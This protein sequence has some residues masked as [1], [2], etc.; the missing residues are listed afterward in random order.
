[1]KY[2][3]SNFGT[4]TTLNV[5]WLN[6]PEATNPAK[7]DCTKATDGT[8]SRYPLGTVN[9]TKGAGTATYQMAPSPWTYGVNWV[10]ATT[11]SGPSEPGIVGDQTF[12]VYPA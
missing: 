7:S 8:L 1:M 6:G 12:T 11:A 5:F 2:S 9:L 10:C 3:F 4:A